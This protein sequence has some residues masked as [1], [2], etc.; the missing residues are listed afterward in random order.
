MFLKKGDAPTREQQTPILRGRC[1]HR[2]R[3]DKRLDVLMIA[4][5]AHNFWSASLKMSEPD[6]P[7]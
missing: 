1:S 2:A 5:A 6:M 3:T 7:A 4:R